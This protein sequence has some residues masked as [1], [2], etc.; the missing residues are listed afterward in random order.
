MLQP[1][2]DGQGYRIDLADEAVLSLG[3]ELER[4]LDLS[5]RSR[6]QIRNCPYL[7]KLW[8]GFESDVA[9]GISI[10]GPEL[11]A[12]AARVGRSRQYLMERLRRQHQGLTTYPLAWVSHHW[13]AAAAVFADLSR[14]PQRQVFRFERR[15]DL[16]GFHDAAEFNF[17]SHS[18]INRPHVPRRRRAC[19]A[20]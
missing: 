15:D 13:R 11:Q 3:L 19:A 9:I 5:A 6:R 20:A 12:Y 8:A 14:F 16:A 4:D 7:P 17:L 1:V 10:E 18:S 2:S